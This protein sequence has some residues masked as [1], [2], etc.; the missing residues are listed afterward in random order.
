MSLFFAKSGIG[1][2]K[3]QKN[4]RIDGNAIVSEKKMNNEIGIK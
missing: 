1:R 2:Q 4:M 3:V